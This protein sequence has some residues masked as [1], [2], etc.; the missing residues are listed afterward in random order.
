ML[1]PP[2]NGEDVLLD[3]ES[4]DSVFVDA[5]ALDLCDL[6]AEQGQFG[7][8]RVS[9]ALIGFECGGAFELAGAEVEELLGREGNQRDFAEE[10]DVGVATDRRVL[11][12]GRDASL[13]PGAAGSSIFDRTSGA[14]SGFSDPSDF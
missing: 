14:S 8:L 1:H 13:Q 7:A 10:M 3:E 5:L 9:I 2:W 6:V 11:G 4:P 12:Q